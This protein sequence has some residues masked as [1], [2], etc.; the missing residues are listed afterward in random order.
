MRSPG[1]IVGIEAN[2]DRVEYAQ[3]SV[4]TRKAVGKPL[5][6][7]ARNNAEPKH[8]L[9]CERSSSLAAYVPTR[10]YRSQTYEASISVGNNQF[11]EPK[12][13]SIIPAQHGMECGQF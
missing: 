7:T 2:A 3:R 4:S 6:A 10:H 12:W 13:E 8:R 5:S 11:L 1:V 9:A